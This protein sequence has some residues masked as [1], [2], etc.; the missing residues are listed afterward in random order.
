MKVIINESK[1]KKVFFEYLDSMEELDVET[2]SRYSDGN[3]LVYY[4]VTGFGYG[5]DEDEDVEY[6]PV[7]D[8]FIYYPRWEDYG[9][10][11]ETYDL[12]EFPLIELDNDIYNKLITMFSDTIFHTLAPEWF[13][14]K[15][16]HPVKNVYPQ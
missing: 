14:K 10:E 7:M 11:E 8:S 3:S 2:A 6:E 15:I 12:K 16:G 9:W 5:D 1:A 4:P 13:S